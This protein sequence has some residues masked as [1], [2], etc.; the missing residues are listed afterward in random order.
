MYWSGNVTPACSVE[1]YEGHGLMEEG[2]SLHSISNR[3]K[4]G[5]VFIAYWHFNLIGIVYNDKMCFLL[6]NVYLKLLICT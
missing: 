5:N 3:I 4:R 1:A 2:F 6:M